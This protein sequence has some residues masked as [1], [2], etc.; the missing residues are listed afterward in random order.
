MSDIISMFIKNNQIEDYKN[1]NLSPNYNNKNYLSNEFNNST[2]HKVDMI[3]N[4]N[5]NNYFNC[6]KKNKKLFPLNSTPYSQKLN[7]IHKIKK[8]NNLINSLIETP[9]NENKLFSYRAII[10]KKKYPIENSIS[11]INYIKYN[12]LKSKLDLSSYNGINKLMKE[13]GKIE[14]NKMPIINM[15]K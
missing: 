6:L 15:V 11:P 8:I 10:H 2:D 1:K 7:K 13:I 12:L 3:R 5:N 14:D 9:K 4:V